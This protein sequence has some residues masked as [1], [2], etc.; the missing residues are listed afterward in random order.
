[1]KSCPQNLTKV[2][3]VCITV[4]TFAAIYIERTVISR[5]SVFPS[6]IVRASKET[7]Q[8]KTSWETAKID[9]VFYEKDSP[10]KMHGMTDTDYIPSLLVNNPEIK[11][12][13]RGY[14]LPY[15]VWGPNNQLVGAIESV[16]V[17]IKLNRTFVLPRFMK[18]H[19]D[20]CVL[21]GLYS[22]NISVL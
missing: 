20:K 22:I 12:N 8:C 7:S 16:F 4:L 15:L 19:T 1:M 18:H 21:Y 2:F 5:Q 6:G 14:L 13:S 17:A 9:N 3:C 10:V 11:L